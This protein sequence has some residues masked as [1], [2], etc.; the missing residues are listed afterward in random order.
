M[1]S[2]PLTDSL[3]ASPVAPAAGPA[4]D[5][6]E[7]RTWR[8]AAFWSL[9]LACLVAF[10]VLTALDDADLLRSLET[11]V[12]HTK[13]NRDANYERFDLIAEH[14]RWGLLALPILALLLR[15]IPLTG[16]AR[17]KAFPCPPLVVG[18][19]ALQLC[20][21]AG[22]L[23]GTWTAIA[24]RFWIPERQTDDQIRVAFLSRNSVPIIRRLAA[25]LPPDAKIYIVT[26]PGETP[27]FLNYYLYPRRF[28]GVDSG[29][30]F[31][32]Q[33]DRAEF[34][35]KRR[36]EGYRWVY[37]YRPGADPAGGGSLI[38]LT[39][40]TEDGK[41]EGKTRNEGGAVAR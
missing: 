37:V 8:E 17:K 9:I 26:D 25:I 16:G 35:K 29:T 3:P 2:A 18:L 41:A 6:P 14:I 11:L 13:G 31:A 22:I 7:V 23:T 20:L 24:D 12:T 1:K 28:Y 36:A 5:A 34:W 15:W 21:G 27:I 39:P 38:E 10:A 30:G 19:F 32:E 4:A 40:A 33:T